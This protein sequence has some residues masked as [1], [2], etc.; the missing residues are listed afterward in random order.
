MKYLKTVFIV[1]AFVFVM[2]IT[3]CE[4]DIY[5]E[6]MDASEKT[7]TLES[8][9]GSITYDIEMQKDGTTL[10][11]PI[12]A[13]YKMRTEDRAISQMTMDM[14]YSFLGQDIKVSA[15]IDND[16]MYMDAAG[17]KIKTP[18]NAED[19]SEYENMITARLE[20]T[21]DIL[22]NAERTVQNGIVSVTVTFD[23]NLLREQLIDMF[24]ASFSGAY[25]PGMA[26]VQNL[27]YIS[28]ISDVTMKYIINDDGYITSYGI[29]F[30]M[31]LDINGDQ[32]SVGANIVMTYDNPGQPVEIEMP[33]LDEYEE[34]LSQGVFVS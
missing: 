9:S 31:N 34:D 18:I 8:V 14:G 29:D 5:Q 28:D 4:Q 26:A 19:L 6:Y 25:N 21:E 24:S 30:S 22:K 17:T 20:L 1:L 3:G 12:T 32:S 11:F 33:N 2:L 13:D 15:Y 10:S 27:D 23:G 7:S 16:I